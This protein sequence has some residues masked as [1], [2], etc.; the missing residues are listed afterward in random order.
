VDEREDRATGALPPPAPGTGL[1]P[2][3]RTVLEALYARVEARAADLSAARSAWPCRRGCD[4]C[5][6]HLA[7]PLPGSGAEW[8]YLWEGFRRLSAPQQ[9]AVR[10]RVARMAREGAARPYTC[11][12]LDPSTGACSVYAHRPLTCRSYGF[13]LSRGEGNW[14]H[15]IAGMLAQEGAEGLLWANQDALEDAVRRLDGRT[16]TF[17]EWFAAHPPDSP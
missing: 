3:Q 7:A 10:E 14:C 2:A 16:L 5:C 15:L 4:H 17:F 11:P 9:A 6:R 13:S 8:A 1:S 12:L